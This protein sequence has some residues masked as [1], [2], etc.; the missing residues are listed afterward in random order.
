MKNKKKLKIF[1]YALIEEGAGSVASANFLILRE[2]L[3][4]G[5]KI[6]LIVIKD[7]I[8]P[9]KLLEHKNLRAI[10]VSIPLYENLQKKYPWINKNVIL[11]K[12]LS[13]SFEFLYRR[14]IAR[15]FKR[16]SQ[17]VKYDLVLFLGTPAFMKSKKVTVSWLQGLPHTE[18]KA[19]KEDY[20]R[21][22][23]CSL[24]FFIVLNLYYYFHCKSF[25][26]K[27]KNSD[28]LIVGSNNSIEWITKVFKNKLTQPIFALPYPVDLK[29]FSS[30]N[31]SE[32]SDKELLWLGRIVPR[33]RIDLALKAF[34]KFTKT[35]PDWTFKI[36]GGFRYAKGYARLIEDQKNSGVQYIDHLSRNK[37]MKAL[38]NS[39]ILIQTSEDENFGSSVSEALAYG[40]PVLLGKTNGTKDYIGDCGEIFDTYD[41]KSITKSLNK[42][43][44]KIEK[45]DI[46]DRT[47]LLAKKNFDPNTIVKKLEKILY[48]QIG[49]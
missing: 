48:E 24:I 11:G 10:P 35:N 9:G 43:A 6:D 18:R 4:L 38:Q 42:L 8:Q 39:S 13:Y 47:K 14:Q 27:I 28:C 30:P 31:N 25:E 44:L 20:Y 16:E 7:Y 5:H 19:I 32:K 1:C 23:F 12:F 46:K 49:R 45:T 2:L 22:H 26:R 40:V 17:V 15:N 33:K 36:I 34:K 3:N 37:A 41:I 29:I 21:V